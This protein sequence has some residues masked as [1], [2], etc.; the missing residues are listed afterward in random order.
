M[1][2][3]FGLEFNGGIPLITSAGIIVSGE[4][5]GSYSWGETLTKKT[6]KESSYETIMP[7]NTYVKV[8]LIATKGKC[9]IP[10][11]YMQRDV[12][13]DGA[14]KTEERDDG[15]YTGFNCY[16]Y[17]YEVEEKKI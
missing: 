5:S 14:V 10:F 16:S 4:I 3:G 2:L 13:C 9:D 17:N 8:S 7:P 15:I 11:S 1:K 12:Y 6:S